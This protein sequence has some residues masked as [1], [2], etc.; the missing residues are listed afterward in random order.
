MAKG[1]C[2]IVAASMVG[3][4]STSADSLVAAPEQY[5]YHGEQS[6]QSARDRLIRTSEGRSRAG[7]RLWC[8]VKLGHAARQVRSSISKRASDVSIFFQQFPKWTIRHRSKDPMYLSIRT[9]VR[10]R[11]PPID[12][13]S[14]RHTY[15]I[16][17]P[18]LHLLWLKLAP[19]YL[20]EPR[21]AAAPIKHDRQ[22]QTRSRVLRRSSSTQQ[23]SLVS[24]T[25][26]S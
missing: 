26:P 3:A 23:V 4:P 21:P 9:T 5:Q 11:S 10:A 1:A 12:V 17:D 2:M 18:H 15:S 25:S 16:V 13:V 22:A 8:E 19:C 24:R 6:L 20:L 14:A 7:G